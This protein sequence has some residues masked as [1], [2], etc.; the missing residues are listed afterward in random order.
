MKYEN[1]LTFSKLHALAPL[2]FAL[3]NFTCVYFI[4]EIISLFT[5]IIDFT[6][7]YMKNISCIIAFKPVILC[8][9]FEYITAGIYL[10][11]LLMHT[12]L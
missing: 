1:F 8:C 2:N 6:C 12:V 10:K 3:T 5:F 7:I 11:L 9:S 4:P